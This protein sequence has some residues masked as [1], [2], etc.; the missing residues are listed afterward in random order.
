ML[1]PQDGI[2]DRVENW[3]LSVRCWGRSVLGRPGL[4]MSREK[5]H[6]FFSR[7]LLPPL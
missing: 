1:K 2:M 4:I 6:S 7:L 5:A 3:R